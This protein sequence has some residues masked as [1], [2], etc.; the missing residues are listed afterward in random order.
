ML[1]N[2]LGLCDDDGVEAST[3]EAA[4]ATTATTAAAAAAAAAAAGAGEETAVNL[5]LASTKCQQVK[6][7][8]LLLKY[9]GLSLFMP[10]LF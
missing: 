4:A 9:D 8:S 10:M 2:V 5:D 1:M 6:L 7:I 3:G